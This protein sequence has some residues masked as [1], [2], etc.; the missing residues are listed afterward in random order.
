[1]T[2]CY[3]KQPSMKSLRQRRFLRCGCSSG[4]ISLMGAVMLLLLRRVGME[5]MKLR[6]QSAIAISHWSLL[7]SIFWVVRWGKESQGL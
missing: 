4:M 1:M 2:V 5:V 7:D 6:G 3:L